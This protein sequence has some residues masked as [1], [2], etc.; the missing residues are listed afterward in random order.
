MS[1]AFNYAA[2]EGI[3]LL[4]EAQLVSLRHRVMLAVVPENLTSFD[5]VKRLVS[6][7]SINTTVPSNIR[8]ARGLFTFGQQA[9]QP[10]ETFG[11]TRI[12][13]PYLDHHHSRTPGSLHKQIRPRSRQIVPQPLALRQSRQRDREFALTI[14]QHRSSANNVLSKLITQDF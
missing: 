2:P 6:G 4:K 14:H 10:V 13:L 12:L 7:H 1:C 8:S 9:S 11:A 3:Y 5:S